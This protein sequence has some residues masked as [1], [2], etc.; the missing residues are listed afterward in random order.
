M[1]T[2]FPPANAPTPQQ[3]WVRSVQNAVNDLEKAAADV[4]NRS[5]NAGT[6]QAGTIARIQQQVSDLQDVTER[7]RQATD[8]QASLL[9]VSNSGGE[10]NTGDIPGDQTWRW[11]GS[12]ISVTTMVATGKALI[13][14]GVGQVTIHAGNSSIIVSARIRYSWAGGGD[15]IGSATRLFGT[16]G[17]FIGLPL[18]SSRTIPD[19]PTDLPVTFEVEY[20]HWSAATNP[21]SNAQFLT[22]NLSASVVPA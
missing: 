9:T 17:T 21:T 13:Q 16:D 1:T 5:N 10:F 7:L 3:R 20:G 2:Q 12:G 11:V 22:A 19:L 4:K 14:Y 18:N 8:Y 15:T 6:S